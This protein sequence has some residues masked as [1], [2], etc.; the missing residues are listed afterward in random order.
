MDV[1]KEVEDSTYSLPHGQHK[2]VCPM[3]KNKRKNKKDRALSVNIDNERIVYNCHHCGG[4]G[5]ISKRRN[6]KMEVVKKEEKKVIEKP[7]TKEDKESITWLE[8]RGISKQT[9]SDSGVVLGKKKYKPVIGFTYP[10]DRG[11]IEAI[12]YRSANGEKIFWWEGSCNKLW[13]EQTVNEDLPTV[14]NTI[15]I[16]EGEL[17][18]LSIKEAFKDSFNIACYSVPSGAPAKINKGKI[19]PSEDNRFKFL[20]NDK[21]KFED[22]DRII[23]AVDT[24]DSGEALAHEL[25]RRLD[26]ARCYRMDYK[27][28]KDANELLLEEGSDVLREQVLDAEPI[29]LHG[30]NSIDHYIEEFQSLY[31]Q[32]KPKG[33]STGYKSVDKLFTPST[34]NLMVVSG[35]PNEGKSAFVN[36]LVVNLGK[37]YGWKTCFCSFE[38]PPSVHSALLS[39]VITGKPFFMGNNARMSQT[40]KSQAESWIREHIVFQ[41]YMGGEP[42]T[43]DAILEKASSS[44]MRSGVRVLVI[45]P[46]NFIQVDKQTGKET[47]MISDMLT[48]VQ[49]FSKRFDVLTIFVAHPM[50]PFS[51]DGKKNVVSGTDIAGSMAWFSKSDI[52]VTVSRGDLGAEIHCWKCRFGWNGSLGTA[53][54][55][56]NPVNGTYEEVQKL[57]DDY[58]WE[59]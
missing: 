52:G 42:A 23:L 8:G 21:K 9:A 18:Q 35:Y 19:D 28:C 55:S 15:V 13:G 25:S 57:E 26:I 29:P 22:V 40:E 11:G 51:K 44:V 59:F 56:F 20:W 38:L 53:I 3:C 5:V 54:L 58:D 12:K 48:K 1:N 39:Q 4:K 16:T 17:D 24:D 41:D 50:K 34:G 49:Q 32:G 36:Q 31:D 33:V 14:E 37:N 45:D 6:F 27:G 2:I 47:D 46:Y 43:I 7:N 30:L 10:D